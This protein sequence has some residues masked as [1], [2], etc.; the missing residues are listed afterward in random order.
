[1]I[2]F[3][4]AFVQTICHNNA[5]I[6]GL[7]MV[8]NYFNP[9]CLAWSHKCRVPVERLSVGKGVI[10]HFKCGAIVSILFIANCL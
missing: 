9:P 8:K 4:L 7:E 10:L 2:C 1:M 5:N 6:L 3:V